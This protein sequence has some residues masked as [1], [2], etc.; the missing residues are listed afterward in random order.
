MLASHNARY[1]RFRVQGPAKMKLDRLAPALTALVLVVGVSSGCASS[2]EAK[3][4]GECE[5]CSADAECGPGLLCD[6]Y[7]FPGD[8]NTYYR[9][10]TAPSQ[11]GSDCTR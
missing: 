1:W 10:S 3:Q 6:G 4:K 9:C 5:P 2:D 11:G 8:P 7:V